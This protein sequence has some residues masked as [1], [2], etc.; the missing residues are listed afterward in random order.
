[1]APRHNKH[2]QPIGEALPHWQ[3]CQTPQAKT[4]IGR[5]CRLEALDTERHAAAL[6][7]A[8]SLDNEGKNWTYLAYGPFAD[9]DAFKDWLF[10]DCLGADPLFFTIIDAKTKQ[11]VGMTALMR[12]QPQHG[13]IEVGHVHFSPLMQR[14]PMATETM[15]LLMT[16]VF[17][18]LGYRRY[19]WKC[20]SLN[21]PSRQAAERFGFRYEGTFRQALVYNGR[22]RDTAWFSMLDSEWPGQ[23]T[24]FGRWLVPEN[25]DKQGRQ[26]ARLSCC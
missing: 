4:L 1:M 7:E 6:Y 20:D 9:L 15:F 22:S 3:A 19:E 25:F 11:A 10:S 12:I 2:G 24:R 16:Y 8:F 23:K 21:Q 18:E 13:S 5:F 14:T 17:D 26:K